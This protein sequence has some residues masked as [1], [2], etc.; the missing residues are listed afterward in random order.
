MRWWG[1]A[2]IGWAAVSV[3]VAVAV[4]RALRTADRPEQPPPSVGLEGLAAANAATL[5]RLVD[6]ADPSLPGAILTLGYQTDEASARY[7]LAVC[8][9]RGADWSLQRELWD[10]WQ[11]EHAHD[12]TTLHTDPEEPTP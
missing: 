3:P 6:A 11:R 1:W 4:G 12:V 8:A 10:T 5:D 2:L 7:W 9:R